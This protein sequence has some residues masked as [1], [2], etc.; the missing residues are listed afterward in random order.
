MTGT[1]KIPGVL[2]VRIAPLDDLLVVG[3][4][5][6]VTDEGTLTEAIKAVIDSVH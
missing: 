3:Y 6:R 2:T 4:D 1:S 5:A